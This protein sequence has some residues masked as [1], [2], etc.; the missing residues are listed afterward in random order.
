MS[1]RDQHWLSQCANV[2]NLHSFR[3]APGDEHFGCINNPRA[4]LVCGLS[5]HFTEEFMGSVSTFSLTR[6]NHNTLKTQQI[7]ME[8]NHAGKL[9]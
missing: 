3:Q 1:I 7:S 9:Y 2:L 4:P 6:L 8:Q 5:R